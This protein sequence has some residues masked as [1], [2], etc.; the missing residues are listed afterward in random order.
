MLWT[1]LPVGMMDHQVRYGGTKTKPILVSE[2]NQQMGG[3]DLLDQKWIKLEKG[4]STILES[5]FCINW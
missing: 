5:G 4:L 1:G 2:Y 3:V